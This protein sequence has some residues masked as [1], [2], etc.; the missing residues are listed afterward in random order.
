MPFCGGQV[1]IR[2][3]TAAIGMA[4]TGGATNRMA[5]VRHNA[6]NVYARLLL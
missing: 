3:Y 4:F 2:R 5:Q 6:I 1:K